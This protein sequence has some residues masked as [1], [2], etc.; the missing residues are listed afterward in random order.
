MAY[1]ALTGAMVTV[2]STIVAS[3]LMGEMPV[4]IAA[5]VRFLIASPVLLA[6]VWLTGSRLPRLR[7][8]EWSLLCLQAGLGSVGYS[9]LLMLGLS[10]TQ[11]SDASVIAGTLP[12]V[13]AVLSMIVLRERLSTGA[14]LAIVLA[15]LGVGMLSLGDAT[16]SASAS[17]SARWSGNALVLLAMA[18]EALFLLLNKSIKTPI[19][20]LVV[21]AA[22]SVLSL[23]L[24]LIPA[25]FQWVQASEPVFTNRAV[26]AAL[27]YALV[28][29]VIGFY[30]WYRGAAKVSGGEAS[31]FTAVYPV[32]A[33]LLSAVVLGETIYPRHWM[34]AAIA[35]AGIVT[36][37]RAAAR[38]AADADAAPA[39]A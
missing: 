23:L 18:C 32:A 14:I 11:A 24:C 2:G 35:V 38:E 30:L 25:L 7:W 6:L 26:G 27:Y 17:A 34:G 31:L 19:A 1:L 4:F 28:P 33:L 16:A 3:K 5:F 21:A 12:A 13:A 39:K 36:G 9:V 29:T 15:T 8:R 22:M 37:A 20:P 10:L